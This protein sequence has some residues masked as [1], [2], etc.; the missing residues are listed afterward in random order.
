MFQDLISIIT[1]VYNTA[2]Y[3]PKCLDSILRQTH[4]NWELLLIDDGSR[5]NSV[6]IALE[7]TQKDNR[8]RLLQMPENQGQAVARNWGLKEAKGEF[9]AFVDSD[10][11]IEANMYADM[12]RLCKEKQ[13]DICICDTIKQPGLE[14]IKQKQYIEQS[15]PIKELGIRQNPTLTLKENIFMADSPFMLPN[16][17]LRKSLFTEHNISF[18]QGLVWEDTSV[19][20]L[21][22]GWA[23]KIVYLPQPLYHIQ[24]RENSTTRQIQKTPIQVKRYLNDYI[25]NLQLIRQQQ[26]LYSLEEWKALTYRFLIHLR[27]L[28][29]DLHKYTRGIIRYQLY[30]TLF[31]ELKR[32]YPYAPQEILRELHS[33]SR[34]LIF[35]KTLLNKIGMGLYIYIYIQLYIKFKVYNNFIKIKI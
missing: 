8:I 10:D 5:D 21:L 1:P 35:P 31:R 7:Y 17:L 19:C 16:K 24:Q 29:Q 2:E 18:P 32:L 15:I 3:L 12:L 33:M 27:T 11:Y 14:N 25:T 9:I 22:L 23:K 20:A 34:R 4:K 30:F 28:E 13:A 26:K 6:Q